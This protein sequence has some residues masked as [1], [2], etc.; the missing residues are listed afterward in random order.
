LKQT[1]WLSWFHCDSWI[2]FLKQKQM[3]AKIKDGLFIGDADTS[4]DTEFL[5]LNKISS[6]INFAGME[7]DNAW[8]TQGFGNCVC[9]LF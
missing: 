8:S 5:E 4:R 6:L 1:D 7:V 3:A 2:Q 9:Y